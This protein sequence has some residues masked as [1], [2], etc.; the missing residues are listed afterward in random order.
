V[1]GLEVFEHPAA[2]PPEARDVVDPA[3]GLRIRLSD[4]NPVIGK[5]ALMG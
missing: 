1:R 2:L 4:H 3:T 5:F